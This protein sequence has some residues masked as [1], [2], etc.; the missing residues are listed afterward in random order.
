MCYG[1]A[2][3]LLFLLPP[4]M[5][6]TL[7]LQT[8]KWAA[9][10]GMLPQKKFS[11]PAV[12]CLGLTFPNSLGLAAG[13]D[14][15]GEYIDALHLLG[16]GFLEIGTVTP[17]PQ[18]GHK[19]PRL[20]RLVKEKAI[21]N[22]MGFNSKGALYVKKQLEKT[23]YQ[24]VLGINLGKNRDTPLEK[25]A[26]D[27][28]YGMYLFW[29]HASYF[30][31]NISSPNTAGLRDL[32]QSSHLSDLL[33]KLKNAQQDI[34]TQHQ[35]YIPLIVKIAPDLN[36]TEIKALA[37]TLLAQKI[38]GVIATNTTVDREGVLASPFAKEA[39][40]LSGAPLFAKSTELLK[41]LYAALDNKIPIIAAGGIMNAQDAST[42]QAAGATL[43]QVYTGLIYQGP[44]LI[45]EI[46][47]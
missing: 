2:R 3:R 13:L 19:K 30:T 46:L 10:L 47:L 38:D 6:H 17:K 42:K 14:K 29:P 7:T 23:Q 12:N 39:G 18:K 21:I 24:G 25:A 15:N 40:G 1:I 37:Q 16:F 34:F 26:E 44:R 32:Q 41:M 36:E 28:L 20:F 27:Y 35:K 8:L 11:A 31:I 4:E 43:L 5:A 45:Q 22:R 9:T 33:A